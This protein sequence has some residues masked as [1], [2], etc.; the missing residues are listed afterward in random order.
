MVKFFIK[1][2]FMFQICF[3]LGVTTFI[4]HLHKTVVFVTLSVLN[5]NS[6]TKIPGSPLLVKIVL[7]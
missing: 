7:Y 3:S 4:A 5:L 2:D 1:N 6:S